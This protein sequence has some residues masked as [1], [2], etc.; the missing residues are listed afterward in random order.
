MNDH[1]AHRSGLTRRELLT[2]TAATGVAFAITNLG[3]PP[4]SAAAAP[5]AA[6]LLDPAPSFFGDMFARPDGA[7]GNGWTPLIGSWEITGGDRL[8]GGTVGFFTQS[9]HLSVDTVS[10]TNGT[11]TFTDDFAR[12]DGPVGN[13]WSTLNGT[14]ALD[15]GRVAIG[16]APALADVGIAQDGITLGDD[17]TIDAVMRTTS[18][19]GRWNGIAFNV[20]PSGLGGWNYYALRFSV[21]DGVKKWQFYRAENSAVLGSAIATGSFPIDVDEDARLILETG[22]ETGELTFTMKDMS[23]KTII[24]RTIYTI[25]RRLV[26][27]SGPTHR[28]IAQTDFELDE[29]FAIET[30]LFT[31]NSSGD[32]WNGVAFNIRPGTSGYD[33]LLLRIANGGKWELQ[34][35]VNSALT[36]AGQ[37]ASGTFEAAPAGLG[38]WIEVTSRGADEVTIKVSHENWTL[39]LPETPISIPS[40][41]QYVG[42]HAGFY[43]GNGHISIGCDPV[44]RTYRSAIWKPLEWAPFVGPAYSLDD[45]P[46]SITDVSSPGTTWAGHRVGQA[47]LTAGSDQYVAYYAANRSITVAHRTLPSG[48]WTTKELDSAV[49]WD[50]HNYLTMALDDDGHLHVS[51]NL[52]AD[53]LIYYRTT[54]AGSVASL[55]RITTMVDPDIE[56]SATYPKFLRGPADELLFMYR[57]GQSDDGVWYLNEYDLTTT[58]WSQY[59]ATPIFDGEGTR[60]PYSY[61]PAEAYIPGKGPDGNYHMVFMWRVGAGVE[62]N[63]LVSYAKSADLVNWQKYDGTPI[64]LPIT[65]GNGDVVD[66][67]LT[68]GGLLNSRQR[69]GFD[70]AGKPVISY[71]KYDED[72]RTA[73]YTAT[74]GVAGWSISRATDWEG[75]F[76]LRGGGTLSPPYTISAPVALPDG[77]V[78]L[79]YTYDVTSRSIILDSGSAYTEVDTPST[80]DPDVLVPESTWPGISVTTSTDIGGTGLPDA[81]Y[82]IAWETLT[83]NRDRPLPEPWPDA[84]ALKVYRLERPPL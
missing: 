49:E 41:A 45:R 5:A 30:A 72:G 44:R 60:N 81:R 20:Q 21:E 1:E 46:W 36:I 22:A 63:E 26:S 70:S 23:G 62:T 12:P 24:N 9:G 38:Y 43:S 64:T 59:L 18:T 83:G 42:G 17:F 32:R 29:Q 8:T 27:P 6:R 10:V 52:H 73:I 15:D 75:L 71:I 7:P 37:I 82:I 57:D 65:Y 14:W 79:D 80:M 66:P 67:T 31:T 58:S 25:N 50:S 16:S 53:P 13:G 4:V 68:R 76:Y 84:E 48:S 69:I 40:A 19:D 39:V 61:G 11:S 2:Y 34:S 55:T 51:G 56:Q 47:L 78:R 28:I 74:P 33:Y 77:K 3:S 35:V 54:V